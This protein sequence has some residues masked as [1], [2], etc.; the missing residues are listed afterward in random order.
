MPFRARET[1]QRYGQAGP[2]SVWLKGSFPLRRD[3]SYAENE[4]KMLSSSTVAA[5][6]GG[7][8][9]FRFIRLKR[10]GTEEH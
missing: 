5:V 8:L 4:R 2:S 7:F 3:Q 10:P 6:L 9:H 1:T